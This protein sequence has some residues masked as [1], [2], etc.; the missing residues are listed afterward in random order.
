LQIEGT[1]LVLGLPVR[2]GMGF[3]LAG[4]IIPLPSPNSFFWGGYGGSL[5]II[6][7]DNR[8]TYAYT[9]NRMV[10]TTTGDMRAFSLAMPMWSQ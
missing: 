6:D 2:Y 7:M 10:G 8:A 4:G 3:G 9:M 5:A 1:D